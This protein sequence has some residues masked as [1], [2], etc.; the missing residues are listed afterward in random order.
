MH[1][2]ESR[3]LR[4]ETR[5]RQRLHALQFELGRRDLALKGLRG[6]RGRAGLQADEKTLLEAELL[7]VGDSVDGPALLEQAIAIVDFP[8]RARVLCLCSRAATRCAS[9]PC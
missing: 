5:T 8:A 6:L 4:I 9:C 2:C 7:R 1:L 3:M